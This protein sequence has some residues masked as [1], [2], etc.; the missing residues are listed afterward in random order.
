MF[1]SRPVHALVI[2]FGLLTLGLSLPPA[3]RS[4]PGDAPG[5]CVLA[6]KPAPGAAACPDGRAK[7]AVA[8]VDIAS[9]G[10][11][12]HLYAGVEASV[13]VDHAL[14]GTVHE[15]FPPGTIPGDAG[16]FLVVDGTLYAP[17]FGAHGI[18]A[19][20]NLGS[21]TPF[22]AVSQ[23]AV[24]GAGTAANPY[25]VTTV[26]AAGNSGVRVI[27]TDTYQVGLEAYRSDVQI[28]NGSGAGHSVV[29]Y[30]AGDCYLGSSDYGYGMVAPAVGAV[31]CTKTANN[32]PEGRILQFVPLTGGSRYYEARYSEVWAWIGTKQAFPNTCRCADIIDNGAGLSWNQWLPAG[33]QVT[34][35]HMTAFS[36]LGAL[37][38]TLQKTADAATSAPGTANGY[39][40][41]VNNPNADDVTQTA[42]S[43]DLPAG[44]GYVANSTTGF[45][46]ANPAQSGQKLTWSGQFTVP[47]A[48]HL[49][50]HFNVNVS[51]T[52]GA[53]TNSASGVATNYS[54]TA[55]QNVAPITVAA[56]VG[57]VDM[58]FR[59]NPD[60]YSFAN[61]GGNTPS[62]FTMDDLIQMFGRAQVCANAS[63]ACQAREAASQWRDDVVSWMS[64]GHCDGFTT[65]ALR[66]FK[67]IDQQ[68][69]FQPNANST[70][71]LTL[72][73]MRRRI[74]YFWALQ[75]P[76]PVG[77]ARG[78]ALSKTP[79]QVLQH[80]YLA[81]SGGAPDPV[82]LI[83][84][85]S[86]RT[87]GHSILPYAIEDAGGGVYRV[88]V[89]DNNHPNDGNRSVTINTTNNTWSY[90]LGGGIGAWSGTATTYSIGVIALSTY[91]QQPACPWCDEAT[92][93][94]ALPPPT[95]PAADDLAPKV[96]TWLQGD[97]NLLVT[98]DEGR[99][100][101]RVGGQ[102]IDEM[103][104]AFATVLPG[105]LGQATQPI[106]YLP[107]NTAYMLAI[108]GAGGPAGVTQYGPGY[109]VA[110]EGLTAAPQATQGVSIAAD[111]RAIGLTPATAQSPKLT[112]ISESS[113]VSLRLAI[114]PDQVKQGDTVTMR[115]EPVSGRL[116]YSHKD[117]GAGTY[118]VSLRRVLAGGAKEFTHS[119]VAI[120][121]T[122]THYI[123][124]G[125]WTGGSVTV[126]I[127]RQSDGTIDETKTLSDQ[128]GQIAPIYLP[129]AL[130][131]PYT[132]P[133]LPLLNGDFEAGAV[134]WAEY[135]NHSWPI[136]LSS[137]DVDGLPVRGGRW[138]AWLGGEYDE[139]AFISQEVTV[140]ADR[141]FLTY[142]H[143]IASQDQC[144]YDFGGVLVNDEV[145]DVYDLCD[146]ADT[147]GYVLHAVNLGAYAGQTVTLQIRVE[148]DGS[149]NSNLFVDDVSFSAN[150]AARA[151]TGRGE[152]PRL[153]LKSARLMPR[154]G[155]AAATQRLLSSHR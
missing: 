142:Y 55:V 116:V 53:Y 58:G 59:V 109:A 129:V 13:Q 47:A 24:L 68:S 107:D 149:R 15:F 141:P 75:V 17:N 39:T 153:D 121:A 45:T 106:F 40:I 135:S 50:L 152:G 150:G 117:A 38:L 130:Q 6:E 36:P 134:Q 33:G 148:T 99:R 96:Q 84:Y 81:L 110:V 71:A 11:L 42:L 37:P 125:S 27:Q 1:T 83:V 133:A 126:Q 155:P 79:T 85:N 14:D 92:R 127:D 65:T 146:P 46:T 60:G 95:Q 90:D 35:S 3:A 101:G 25:R 31:A 28:S 69:T 78:N 139:I 154:V 82:T 143:L 91:A 105:G 20:G 72:A 67:D 80:L 22:T 118:T 86:A 98:D 18:T 48:G 51:A 2:L 7:S 114:E 120:G 5:G 89:Y 77:A 43:D 145:V 49:T 93:Q 61:Y 151:D 87:S 115:Q 132:P 102:F 73:N 30:R 144:G 128:T 88:K 8:Y 124:Y 54:V 122:D 94:N 52:P 103:P 136:I 113:A 12:T 131:I 123:G 111:G 138:A 21:Y 74:A 29:L 4:Q 64:G 140:P 10:P 66:F 147:G 108:S 112:L 16:T 104:D 32:S 70:Y 23:T 26:V 44:F 34:W 119:Q 97:G 137:D 63:G 100:L 19:T 62:D 76:N 56:Q 41:T 57:P 9:A